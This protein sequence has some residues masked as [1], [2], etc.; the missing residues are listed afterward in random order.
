[1]A[2]YVEAHRPYD[3][4]MINQPIDPSMPSITSTFDV[5][6]DSPINAIMDIAKISD[7]DLYAL[8]RVADA[9]AAARVLKHAKGPL[10]ARDLSCQP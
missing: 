10:S 6:S 1:M 4:S 3:S 7:V 9:L 8:H 5:A 2:L